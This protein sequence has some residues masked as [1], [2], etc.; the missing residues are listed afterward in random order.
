MAE[1]TVNIL[2]K[3]P[4]VSGKFQRKSSKKYKLI[5]KNHKFTK[6]QGTRSETAEN[7]DRRWYRELSG[8]EVLP[9]GRPEGDWT[10]S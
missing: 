5:A 7:I 3:N 6:K 10:W 4:E 9:A 8:C 2:G 1:A